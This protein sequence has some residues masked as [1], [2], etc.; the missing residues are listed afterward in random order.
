MNTYKYK[1]VKKYN[2]LVERLLMKAINKIV[3]LKADTH[4]NA[5]REIKT[6]YPDYSVDMTWQIYR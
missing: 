4:D 3:V 2:T 5:N 6:D 1:L